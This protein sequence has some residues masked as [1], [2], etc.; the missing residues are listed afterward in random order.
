M[1]TQTKT[2]K[3]TLKFKVSIIVEPDT[4]GFHSYSPVLKGLHM[5]GDTEQEALKNARL[6]AKDFI[7]I[8]IEDNLPIPLCVITGISAGRSRT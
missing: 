4:I 1:T 7:E 8:M 5:D 2:E 6:A 3:R